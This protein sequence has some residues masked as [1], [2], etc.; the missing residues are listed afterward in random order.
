M[1]CDLILVLDAQ[2]PRE[3]TPVLRQLQGTVR[4]A[5]VGL[6]MFSACGPAAS[7]RAMP[8]RPQGFAAGRRDR[9]TP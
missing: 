3:V 1:A 4:W 5:K 8:A 9:G 2:S 7:G 6:E